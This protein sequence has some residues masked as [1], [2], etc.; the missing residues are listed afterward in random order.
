LVMQRRRQIREGMSMAKSSDLDLV[1]HHDAQIESLNTRMGAVENTLTSH[2]RV[3]QEIKDAVV[4]QGARPFFDPM[5]TVSVVKDIGIIFGLVCTGILYLASVNAQA[6]VGANAVELAIVKERERVAVQRI[7]RME[8]LV[9][10]QSWAG[11]TKP[12]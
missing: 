4:K 1:A 5:R 11:V 12:D 7:E 9:L 8:S 2:G 3:L 6:T 10:P